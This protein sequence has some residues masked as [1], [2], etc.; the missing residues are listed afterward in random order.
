MLTGREFSVC[1][2][3]L[4]MACVEEQGPAAR[5]AETDR[6]SRPNGPAAPE[7]RENKISLGFAPTSMAV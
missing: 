1:S 6:G 4:T 5:A 7:E 3:L 2:E